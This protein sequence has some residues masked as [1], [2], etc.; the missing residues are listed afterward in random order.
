MKGGISNEQNLEYIL[1]CI[2]E[3]PSSKFWAIPISKEKIHKFSIITELRNKG[4]TFYQI[5]DYL[6]SNG[7]ISQRTQKFTSEWVFGI[8]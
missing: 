1:T 5:S 8:H 6:N 2:L 7:Y 4:L 3:I